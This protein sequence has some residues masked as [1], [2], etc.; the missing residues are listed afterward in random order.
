MWT[1]TGLKW[2]PALIGL[3]LLSFGISLICVSVSM[4]SPNNVQNPL[5]D[6]LIP[7]FLDGKWTCLLNIIGIKAHA[8]LVPILVIWAIGSIY[9][10]KL[11]FNRKHS[12]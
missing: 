1:D 10:L 3:F 5:F 6:F 7:R 2:K 4:F 9:I 8:A 11:L 12:L